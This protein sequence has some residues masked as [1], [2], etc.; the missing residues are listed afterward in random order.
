[1]LSDIEPALF[2]KL[3]HPESAETWN[4]WTE[5]A[6]VN[7]ILYG[8]VF[9]YAPVQSS[10][11]GDCNIQSTQQQIQVEDLFRRTGEYLSVRDR[12]VMSPCSAGEAEQATTGEEKPV[13]I[14]DQ[15]AQVRG[16]VVIYPLGYLSQDCL[17]PA[18]GSGAALVQSHVFM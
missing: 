13:L 5:A 11:D 10:L 9:P 14:S 1:M 16:R 12:R 3:L 6:R 7:S 2:D 17:L 18:A 8:K 4:M 15:L